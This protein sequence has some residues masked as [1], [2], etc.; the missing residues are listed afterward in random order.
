MNENHKLVIS[1]MCHLIWCF[2]VSHYLH[3]NIMICALYTNC[4]AIICCIFIL[5]IELL[6]FCLS[7]FVLKQKYPTLTTSGKSLSL[8]ITQK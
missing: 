5:K 8:A 2:L 6:V 3:T 7:I 4:I 1:E